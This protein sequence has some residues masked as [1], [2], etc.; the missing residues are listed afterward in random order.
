[1]KFARPPFGQA[2]CKPLIR[3]DLTT[4][5]TDRHGWEKRAIVLSV[6]IREIRGQFPKVDGMLK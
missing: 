1:M 3:R 2:V 6:C 4:D 5:F